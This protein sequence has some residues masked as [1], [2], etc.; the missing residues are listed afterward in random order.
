M[1]K[2][3][4]HDA[5]NGDVSGEAAVMAKL[6]GQSS[7]IYSTS[8]CSMG[9]LARGKS[10]WEVRETPRLTTSN[11]NLSQCCSN[12]SLASFKS[13]RSISCTSL[14]KRIKT[15][16]D[17]KIAMNDEQLVEFK[18]LMTDSFTKVLS[19]FSSIKQTSKRKL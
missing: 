12:V 19:I 15:I 8:Q 3:F 4:E 16:D 14:S 11:M 17:V 1:Q 13:G 7:V 10:K 9:Q 2:I 6:P 18:S 5:E